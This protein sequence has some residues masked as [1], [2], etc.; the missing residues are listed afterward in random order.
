MRKITSENNLPYLQKFREI[1][2]LKFVIGCSYNLR[3]N[4]FGKLAKLN[5]VGQDQE[6]L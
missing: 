2:T 4:I 3:Q 1:L 5:D 6:T